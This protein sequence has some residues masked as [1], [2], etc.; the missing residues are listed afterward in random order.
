MAESSI[1]AGVDEQTFRELTEPYRAELR[2]HCYRMLGSMYDAEDA[3]Q[4]TLLAAWR[5]MAEFEQR[6][7]VRTWLYRIATNRCLNFRRAALRRPVAPLPFDAPEPTRHAEVSWL[8]P[9]P[10]ALLDPQQVLTARAS[11][12]LAFI[13]LLQRLPPRQ[14]AVLVLRDVLEFSAAEVAD[15]LGST[16][17]AVKA[18]LQRARERLSRHECG[19]P[20]PEPGSPTERGLSERFA[21]AFEAADVGAVVELLTDEAWL[22]MPPWPHEYHGRAAIGEFLRGIPAFRDRAEIRLQSVRANAH[23]AFGCYSRRADGPFRATGLL[24]TTYGPDGISALA[25]FPPA[26]NFPRFGLPLALP[27]EGATIS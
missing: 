27:P 3:L 17:V 19:R 7:S 5:G 26:E 8:Q 10:D 4:E 18:A 13:A 22:T 23:P 1:A 14:A 24:V 20:E 6:S 15:L 21:R 25:H 16:P 11:V 9:C 2:T 12:E